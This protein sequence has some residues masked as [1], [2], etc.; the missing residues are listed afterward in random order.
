MFGSFLAF[1]KLESIELST[2]LSAIAKSAPSSSLSSSAL[3]ENNRQI[4]YKV[5]NLGILLMQT[6]VISA[7]SVVGLKFESLVFRY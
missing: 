4:I 3:P 5:N 6:Y 7:L 2:S 1:V